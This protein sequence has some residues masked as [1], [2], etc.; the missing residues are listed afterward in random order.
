MRFWPGKPVKFR[1]F[2]FLHIVATL[3]SYLL[4]YIIDYS[5]IWI[6]F[7]IVLRE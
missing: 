3:L 6:F 5:S 4:N 1:E 2:R 7:Q